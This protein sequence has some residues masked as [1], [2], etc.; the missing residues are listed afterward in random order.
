MTLDTHGAQAQQ[1]EQPLLCATDICCGA[2]SREHAA[3]RMLSIAS[4]TCPDIR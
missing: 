4:M 1:A 2:V 3:S